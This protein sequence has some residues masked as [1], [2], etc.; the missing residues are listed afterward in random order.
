MLD[1][2]LSRFLATNDA[3]SEVEAKEVQRISDEALETRLR[4]EL[5]IRR[6]QNK[7]GSE[8]PIKTLTRNN[9]SLRRTIQRC[10]SI[11]SPI[12]RLPPEILTH[13]FILTTPV[14][15]AGNL[16]WH[17]SLEQSPWILGHICRRWRAVALTSPA[18]WS[19]IVIQNIYSSDDD[20][21]PCSIPMLK[22]QLTRSG[23]YPLEVV[24]EYEVDGQ[25]GYVVE[26]AL[27][28]LAKCSSRWKS[29]S[30][31]AQQLKRLPNI[32]G[33][34]PLLEKL[35][36]VGMEEEETDDGYDSGSSSR[37]IGHFAI[38]P[39][40]RV[41]EMEMGEP[42]FDLPLVH[43][44]HYESNGSWEDHIHALK[45]LRNVKSCSLMFAHEF[46]GHDPFNWGSR[47]VE[48]SELWKLDISMERYN[49][50]EPY[51]TCPKWL[52]VPALTSLTIDDSLLGGLPELL[53]TSK[54]RLTALNVA[55]ACPTVEATRPVFESTPDLVE[56]C[57]DL[58]RSQIQPHVPE[59]IALLTLKPHTRVVLPKL[60]KL[61]MFSPPIEF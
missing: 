46:S 33:R 54:C 27:K 39:R 53:Q 17:R 34:V 61:E 29:L 26:K 12:R 47:T 38:A 58:H 14:E 30:I 4:N 3:P 16:P 55:G 25:N 49:F 42:F 7:A 15:E 1:P 5:Q 19:S 43:L 44:T 21:E 36:V 45:A 11:L 60:R 32:R 59:L 31:T 50:G 56:L 10:R 9:S 57:I 41:V 18:L 35:S 28:A 48:L 20:S 24:F 37:A 13:I 8:P 23:S 2:L 22:A 40:L 52:R 51:W 6:L